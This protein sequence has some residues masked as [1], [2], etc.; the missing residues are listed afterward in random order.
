MNLHLEDTLIDEKGN[1]FSVKGFEMIRLNSD[2]FPEWYLKISFI[3]I[4]G[5]IENIGNYLAL[6]KQAN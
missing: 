2:T 4:T 3:S 1:L 5:E 6:Y